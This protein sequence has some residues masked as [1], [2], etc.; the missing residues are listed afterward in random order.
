[1]GEIF[2]R[3]IP[4]DKDYAILLYLAENRNKHRVR[5]CDLPPP[6]SGPKKMLVFE[7]QSEEEDHGKKRY[8]TFSIAVTNSS[9]GG[10]SDT[11][12]FLHVIP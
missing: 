12:Y 10:I 1:V 4:H 6:E 7:P 9:F 3:D 5:G 8:R 11:P 2:S